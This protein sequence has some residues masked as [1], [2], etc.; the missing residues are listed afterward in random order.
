MTIAP[1]LHFSPLAESSLLVQIGDNATIEHAIVET[2]WALTA[3][4]DTL[5]LPGVLDIVP[6]Y[7][8]IL[9]SFDPAQTDHEVIVGNVREVAST[10]P[11]D[12]TEPGRTVEIP[13]CYGGDVGPD[14]QDVA[15][16]ANLTP[17]EVIARHAAGNYRVA[18]GGFA[19]GWDYLM[20]LPP[21]LATPRLSN[22]RTR[23]PPGSLGIGGM[24]T[25]V[26][27][28]ETPG[29]WRLIGRTPL[30]MFDPNRS[31][32]FLLHPGDAVMFRPIDSSEYAVIEN[33][34]AASSTGGSGNFTSGAG[35]LAQS[36]NTASPIEVI[37]PGMLTTV[38]DLGRFG[39]ARYGVAPGGALDRS[40]LI[41]GNR[42]LG[43]DPGE[44]GL[45]ITL[46]G[47]RLVFSDF[48]A[49]ASTLR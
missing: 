34:L 26:Y 11:S 15:D 16:H 39:M 12:A 3:A 5:A 46:L 28:L 38:Q 33:E 47:P 14:L 13:V 41:L 27:P 18:C 1:T 22:P 42:L 17:E 43:N 20:G 40:A 2:V 32:P 31:D 19:P 29:G 24:Q 37:E 45:E 8:T 35:T 21:E 6:A 9:I 25:G 48:A 44:A 36:D 30:K 23:I 49:I 4:L 10:L 7:T